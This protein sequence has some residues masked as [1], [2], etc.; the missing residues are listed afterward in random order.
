MRLISAAHP[1]FSTCAMI[2]GV[3]SIAREYKRQDI[4]QH[5]TDV[6]EQIKRIGFV[7][8][9]KVDDSAS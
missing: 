8:A 2:L 1:R 5:M 6:C 3:A 4:P 7:F 9:L